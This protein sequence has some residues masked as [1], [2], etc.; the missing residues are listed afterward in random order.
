MSNWG[1]RWVL[2]SW[3]WLRA[4]LSWDRL[5]REMRALPYRGQ[6]VRYDAKR[7][8]LYVVPRTGWRSGLRKQ[9][10]CN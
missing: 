4:L 3:G 1:L 7:R 9:D 2:A 10:R 8:R 5:L 6:P